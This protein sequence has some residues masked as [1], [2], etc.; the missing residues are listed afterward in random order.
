[1][2][3]ENV[4]YMQVEL[5]SVGMKTVHI[6]RKLEDLDRRLENS[7]DD[8]RKQLEILLATFQEARDL[9]KERLILKSLAFAH[10]DARF[11]T[12]HAAEPDTF[13]W[14]FNDPDLLRTKETRLAISF[15]DW[16]KSGSGIFHIIGKPGS[17]KSTLMK[18]L[19]EQDET[20]DHL[21]EWAS[22]DGKELIFCTFFFW[23]ITTIA[24]QKTLKGLIRSLLYSVISQV[25]SLS[26]RIFP[27]QWDVKKGNSHRD[28]RVEL[29]DREISDAFEALM[30]DTAIFDE[31]RLCFFIDGLDE[32]EQ[33][34]DL[35]S[36]THA[37]LATKLQKW[38]TGS[39]SHVKMCV[40]SRPL[41]EFTRTFPVS[42]QITLQRLTENDIHTLVTNRLE[43]NERF[44]E[45]R[46]RS[47]DE[48][49]RCDA[50]AEKILGD[51]KGVFLWVVLVLNELEQALA[52]GDSLEIL[53]KIVATAHQELRVFIKTILESIPK[54]YRQGSYYLLAVVMRILGVLTSEAKAAAALKAVV[55]AAIILYDTR[56]YHV[57]LE[58]CAMV[59]DA[60]DKG[61][62]V[63]C[64]ESLALITRDLRDDEKAM[65][66][67]KERLVTRCRGLAE[68]DEELNIR[69][70]HR[71]I[72][73]SLQELF[74]GNELEESVQD[75]SVAHILTWIVLGDVR[76]RW[77]YEC[78]GNGWLD[79]QASVRRLRYV[80]RTRL[81]MYPLP[82]YASERMMRLLY[83]IQEAILLA[84]YGTATPTDDEWDDW[85]WVRTDEVMI[86]RHLRLGVF[87]YFQ[88]HEFTGWLIDTKLSLDKDRKRLLANL[89][90]VVV[91]AGGDFP[92]YSPV[93]FE[94]VV[95]KM[96]E[97]GLT[98]DA[99][100]PP[101][102]VH[103]GCRRA[104][105]QVWHEFLCRE[106]HYGMTHARSR[107][108]PGYRYRDEE[109]R[110]NWGGLETL[111]RFGADPDVYLSAGKEPVRGLLLGST[112]ETL[113]EISLDNTKKYYAN[114]NFRDG[115]ELIPLPQPGMVSLTNYVE[116][117]KPP[118]MD[119]LLRLIQ[120]N[121]KKKMGRSA[122]VV[123]VVEDRTDRD[124]LYNSKME[125]S[126][127]AEQAA[128]ERRQ[129]L[130]LRQTW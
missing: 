59:F 76:R 68:V 99:N 13:D 108:L 31:F 30:K 16:L 96:L 119:E 93:S 54:R 38:A 41:V 67:E 97:R 104:E 18:F 40:S 69:F 117:H 81:R 37:S 1:M 43:N 124:I 52:N 89:C 106:L 78:K 11:R 95:S 123:P 53:E 24:E 73:E 49:S 129:G 103:S 118:N 62:L 35:Q 39:G 9:I 79:D 14:I 92:H 66:G 109:R 126:D 100:H 25:P 58:E 85:G 56:E 26:R 17:G 102:F 115:W 33:N 98:L 120:Q 4:A 46:K 3:S 114:G 57:S 121:I 91:A 90:E 105:C 7:T 74:S 130:V 94:F 63:D 5:E 82:L 32:F 107:K 83:S 55:D 50:L 12:I 48:N 88:L 77:K 21:Q 127:Q 27:K 6:S 113:Y 2:L 112:G 28:L 86:R 72:P 80:A 128:Q 71:S 116:F 110:I 20:R 8:L 84:Q 22:A 15:T 64:D 51:A 23:R 42:Q 19:C 75:E 70:T 44:A 36:D 61:N 101:G 65:V 45:L 10:M 47:E 111:L 125:E 87:D 122:L 34:I 60:A 29:G